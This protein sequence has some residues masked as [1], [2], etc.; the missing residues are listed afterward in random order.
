MQSLNTVKAQHSFQQP[1]A[2]LI[3]CKAVDTAHRNDELA[4][5]PWWHQNTSPKTIS[6]PCSQ[7]CNL[8]AD[9][10]TNPAHSKPQ[11]NCVELV[12]KQ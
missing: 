8:G 3:T 6:F 2:I 9:V 12:N 11:E 10:R 7:Q 1:Q 4:W 5:Q